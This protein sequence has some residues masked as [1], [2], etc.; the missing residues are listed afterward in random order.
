[1]I[2]VIS[3]IHGNLAALEA[4]LD[5]IGD[6]KTIYCAGDI[7]GYGPRPNECCELLRERDVK[8]VMGNHDIV[9]ANFEH[10]GPGDTTI[11]DRQRKL[12]KT[13]RDEMNSVARKTCRWTYHMLT[14][15]NREYIRA[16]PLVLCDGKVTLIHGS[17]GSDYHNLNTYLQEKYETLRSRRSGG[18]LPFTEFCKEL[19]DEVE[20]KMLLVGHTHV[21]YKG[22]IFRGHSS[23]RYIPLLNTE[24]W[25]VNPGSVGQPRDKKEAAYALVELP[26]FPYLRPKA[27]FRFLEHNVKHRR[28]AYDRQGNLRQI[29]RIETLDDEVRFMLTRWF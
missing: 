24:N 27:S 3:D 25:V 17:P 14:R 29:E 18:D 10:L 7:V 28:V 9:A 23:L 20:T 5:E 13:T 19:L 15:E 16:L 4:V 1:M 11:P 8:C 12:A 21:P 26:F 6:V 2:A 22:Y